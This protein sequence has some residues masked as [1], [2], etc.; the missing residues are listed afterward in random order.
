MTSRALLAPLALAWLLGCGDRGSSGS[1]TAAGTAPTT[2]APGTGAS[3]APT[4]ITIRQGPGGR[5]EVEGAAPLKG[6]PQ[7]C[8]QVKACCSAPEMGL[9][10]GLAQAGGD[11]DCAKILKDVQGYMAESKVAKPV[12]CP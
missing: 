11:G 2:A 7:V 9:F 6:D 8:A 12:G 10:C 4:G 1:A 5:T 3:P